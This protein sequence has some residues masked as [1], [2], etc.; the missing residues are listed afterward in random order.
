MKYRAAGWALLA[1]VVGVFLVVP[2][3]HAQLGCWGSI[4][5]DS[6]GRVLLTKPISSRS[7]ISLSTV[8]NT[9]SIPGDIVLGCTRQGA[10]PP[11]LQAGTLRLRP[12]TAPGTMA[13]VIQT[14]TDGLE[15]VVID[16]IPGGSC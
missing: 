15:V 1:L 7:M 12:G 16:N 10:V 6:S 5:Q 4:C 11:G 2:A 13:L 8:P 9:L 14:G 3:L